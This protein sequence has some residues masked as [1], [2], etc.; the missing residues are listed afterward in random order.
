[1]F[2]NVIYC[3]QDVIADRT[4]LR[5][6][7]RKFSKVFWEVFPTFWILDPFCFQLCTIFNILRVKREFSMVVFIVLQLTDRYQSYNLSSL[8]LTGKNP[9]SS[10]NLFKIFLECFT[11]WRMWMFI[12]DPFCAAI[13][14]IIIHAFKCFSFND[15][16]LIISPSPKDW[17]QLF[18]ENLSRRVF[19]VDK[20]FSNLFFNLLDV[21]LRRDSQENVAFWVFFVGICSLVISEKVKALFNVNH[22]CFCFIKNESSFFQK[23]DHFW[24]YNFG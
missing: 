12:H 4:E 17:V 3:F 11:F 23:F 10:R 1:M 19:M 8:H 9:I 7:L 5:L 24:F 15:W 18:N 20:D 14:D 2:F 21:I 16:A 22:L 6:L 13:L